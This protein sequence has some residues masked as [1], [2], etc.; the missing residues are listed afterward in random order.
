MAQ[1]GATPEIA[2][3]LAMNS[4]GLPRISSS[5]V[6]EESELITDVVEGLEEISGAN[7]DLGVVGAR[8]GAG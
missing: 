2:R 5:K 1:P 7:A 3:V 6:I 8:E 4:P